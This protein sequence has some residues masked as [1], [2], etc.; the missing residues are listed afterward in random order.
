MAE[1]EKAEKL[2]DADP[3]IHSSDTTNVV[4]GVVIC[5]IPPGN[6]A[7]ARVLRINRSALKAHLAHGDVEGGC[8]SQQ[9]KGKG[10]QEENQKA[11]PQDVKEKPQPNNNKNDNNNNKGKENKGTGKVEMQESGG[12]LRLDGD[13]VLLASRENRAGSLIWYTHTQE[14]SA[15]TNK[16]YGTVKATLYHYTKTTTSRGIVSFRI[17]DA[18]TGALLSVQKMPGEFV[19]KSEWATFNGDERALSA[20]QLQ[21]TRQKEQPA[22]KPQDLF[23]EFTRPIYDQIT[24]KLKEFYRGY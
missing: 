10:K 14:V 12:E 6:K 7:N 17:I 8:E 2:K 18:K 9:E 19:W 3:T 11:N 24:T 20:E 15:D 1:K 4:D 21:L 13:A 5:H 22:P 23:I 16:V